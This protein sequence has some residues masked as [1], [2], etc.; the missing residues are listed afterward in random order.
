MGLFFDSEDDKYWQSATARNNA[1]SDYERAQANHLRQQTELEEQR[2]KQEKRRQEQEEE[3]QRLEQEK[4]R[5]ERVLALEGKYKGLTGSG[6]IDDFVSLLADY[7]SA[8]RN[9]DHDRSKVIMSSL[10]NF[11][12]PID[13]DNVKEFA[14]WLE[15][16][17][18]KY[19]PVA[20][21]AHGKIL[22]IFKFEASLDDEKDKRVIMDLIN[23]AMESV[24]RAI[25]LKH[26]DDTVMVN[27]M[28]EL[29]KLLEDR[30]KQ[31]QILTEKLGKKR[32]NMI[33]LYTIGILVLLLFCLMQQG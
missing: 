22:G 12:F 7:D 4:E 27:E 1:R 14:D 31:S 33:W 29:N 15:M 24:S 2:L 16:N 13:K 25:K 26:S 8:S 18:V 5:R 10:N 17:H 9:N 6:K 28:C 3:R 23:S 30:K 20:G 19:P 11:R 21:V 32:K